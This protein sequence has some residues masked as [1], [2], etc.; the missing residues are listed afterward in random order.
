MDENRSEFID[1]QRQAT[2]VLV[3]DDEAHNRE[4]LQDILES[5]GFRTTE[6]V[7]GNEALQCALQNAPDVILLDVMMPHMDGFETCRR[8]RSHP[9]LL[10]VPVLM[11]TALTDRQSRLNG[12]E[13]GAND[14]LTKP[15]DLRETLMRV[16]NAAALKHLTDRA[17]HDYQQIQELERLK[18]NL[19]HMVVHDLRSPMTGLIGYLDLV[20]DQPNDLAP[21]A[22]SLVRE[23]LG[24]AQH[25]NEMVTTLLDVS[26]LESGN[27]PLHLAEEDLAVISR[28]AVHNLGTLLHGV[29]LRYS[30]SDQLRAIC[31]RDVLRRVL[32]NLL[33]NAVKY[34]PPQGQITLGFIERRE[35]AEVRIEDE[36]PGI[37]E[38]ERDRV[39]D[40]FYRVLNED[41]DERLPAS[42]LGLSFCKL[43]VEAHRGR[44]YVDG[45]YRRGCAF[46]IELPVPCA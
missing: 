42:G 17:R 24:Q 40:K 31:D 35:H 44:I 27:M 34:S 25:L 46:V 20:L 32:Q 15:I 29:A 9:E 4:L 18:D 19:V 36:G 1:T 37:P 6:A 38:T 41:V 16:K 30:G 22:R 26:R 2:H 14:F 39:F 45:G 21:S 10:H 5:E 33:S 43:A 12:I 28:K 8:I 3:V 7:D 23:A 13:A 11:I